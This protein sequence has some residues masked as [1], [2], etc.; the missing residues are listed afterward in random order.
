MVQQ[1]GEEEGGA[2]EAVEQN[3]IVELPHAHG[4]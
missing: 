1:G 3:G 4:L 2:G